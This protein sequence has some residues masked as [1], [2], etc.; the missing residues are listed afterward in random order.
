MPQRITR[1]TTRL[2]EAL[3]GDPT[4]EWY[5]LELMEEA[6]LASG[7]A[8]PLLHRLQRDGWLTSTREDVD[9]RQQ[10]RPRRRLYRLTA[11]GETAAREV[12]AERADRRLPPQGLPARATIA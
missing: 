2:L 4:R 3:L 10:G 9:P 7:T 6:N 12:V 1:Q 8:Y 11:L 5:G